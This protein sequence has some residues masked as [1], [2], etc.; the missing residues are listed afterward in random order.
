MINM[1]KEDMAGLQ[2]LRVMVEREINDDLAN[3]T[4]DILPTTIVNLLTTLDEGNMDQFHGIML[5]YIKINVFKLILR[6]KELEEYETILNTKSWL[7]LENTLKT[8]DTYGEDGENESE[9]SNFI[10]NNMTAYQDFTTDITFEQLEKYGV[11]EVFS[12][13]LMVVNGYQYKDETKAHTLATLQTIT[14]A[15]MLLRKS[16]EVDFDILPTDLYEIIKL[17]VILII[18]DVED[19][20]LVIPTFEDESISS[21]IG[22][23]RE[24]LLAHSRKEV[25][26]EK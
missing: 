21:I 17:G 10:N 9:A 11:K 2:D 16:F 25:T 20:Q 23:S 26:D 15:N 19:L 7:S 12:M 22:M 24:E 13:L 8:L 14:V 5:N 18:S 6:V 4:M 1:T 3:F